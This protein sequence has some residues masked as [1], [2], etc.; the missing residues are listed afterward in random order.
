[1]A[2]GRGFQRRHAPARHTAL[3]QHSDQFIHHAQISAAVTRRIA[4]LL[5]QIDYTFGLTKGLNA[6]DV[7]IHIAFNSAMS[8]QYTDAA[9]AARGKRRH[10]QLT[11]RPVLHLHIDD[12]IVDH[13]VIAVIHTA[14]IRANTQRLTNALFIGMKRKNAARPVGIARKNAGIRMGQVDIFRVI[15]ARFFYFRR[16]IHTALGS[17]LR[18]AFRLEMAQ[19]AKGRYALTANAAAQPHEI[20]DIVAAL[21]QQHEGGLLLAAPVSAHI[22][23]RLMPVAHVFK[24]LNAYNVSDVPALNRRTDLL[25]KGA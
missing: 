20:V 8:T 4:A 2:L 22:A 24:C 1:M 19:T 17:A 6:N 7:F 11:M 10:H 18:R 25:K 12:L 5:R 23:M 14:A 16:T 13:I 15:W 21:G 9:P 3:V